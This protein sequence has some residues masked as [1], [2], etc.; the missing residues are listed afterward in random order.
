MYTV[1]KI[2][3]AI[4][5]LVLFV[6]IGAVL[7][8][9][10]NNEVILEDDFDIPIA[11]FYEN[12]EFGDGTFSRG[13]IV[14]IRAAI[15]N[16]GL[17]DDEAL[18]TVT[19]EL[20]DLQTNEAILGTREVV[21]IDEA[22][23]NLQEIEYSISTLSLKPAFAY[24]INIVAKDDVRNQ[25]ASFSLPF[26]I[27]PALELSF[28]G[29]FTGNFDETEI[30]FDQTPKIY[31]VGDKVD[32]YY[33][34]VGFENKFTPNVSVGLVI[35]DESGNI[36]ENTLLNNFNETYQEPTFA[37]TQN[38]EYDTSNLTNGVYYLKF[39]AKSLDEETESYMRLDLK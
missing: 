2:I 10:S 37:L 33:E 3:F 28:I 5:G 23:N 24:A 36:L 38:F 27:D 16:I 4:M 32:F 1:K 9:P 17:M 7:F 39:I 12:E 6:L 21:L 29:P 11:W 31:S 20:V 25:E 13:D 14:T 26:T 18:V 30:S 15:N 35:A 22:V 8:F 19:L 34:I